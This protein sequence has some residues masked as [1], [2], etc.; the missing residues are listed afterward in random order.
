[1]L[2]RLYIKN[3][4]LIAESDISFSSGLTTITGETGAGKSILL[5]ALGL[6]L[7]QRADMQMLTDK[8]KKCVVEAVF[9]L[10]HHDLKEW[11]LENNLDFARELI[12]RREL[13]PSGSSRA[14]INDT[15]VLLP[16]IKELGMKLIDIHSQHETLNLNSQKFQL[17]VLDN[18]ASQQKVAANYKKEFK[19]YQETVKEIARLS[20]ELKRVQL[21]K[22]YNDFLLSE[23]DQADLKEGEVKEAEQE[24]SVLEN[25]HDIKQALLNVSFALDGA[26]E[27]IISNLT[28]LKTYFKQASEHQEAAKLGERFEAVLIELKDIASESDNLGEKVVADPERQELLSAR[29]DLLNQ[30]LQKHRVQDEADLIKLQEELRDKNTYS[31]HIETE[32]KSAEDLLKTQKK[33][34][35]ELA[36]ILH[37]G[38]LSA[39]KKLEKGVVDKLNSLGMPHATL[40][41]NLSEREEPAEL[42][43]DVISLLFSA[44][45]GMPGG[46]LTKIASGGELSRVMFC[47]KSLTQGIE[48]S[49]VLVFDEIDTGVSG[50]VAGKLG[51][52]M[53]EMASSHQMICITHLPQIA[54]RGSRHLYVYK[55][56]EGSRTISSIRELKGDGRVEEI[57]RMLSGEKVTKAAMENAMQLLTEAQ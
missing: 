27:S 46:E 57:A 38:R 23:L 48:N 21:E 3:F 14:F 56:N 12:M 49:P 35:N 43:K 1:M 41:V 42:G 31:D 39:A 16:Q 36:A 17:S 10:S 52:M 13:S 34:L 51:T 26:D 24:L 28:G 33:N 15:P 8:D 30:L 11:F 45:K 50:E 40:A 6:V 7:G 4:A 18:L 22:D 19:S 53:A 44:N 54:S 20:E 47:I 5:G 32:L 29:I 9:D 2:Q 55:N 25:A 37:K